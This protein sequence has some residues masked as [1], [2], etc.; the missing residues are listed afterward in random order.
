MKGVWLLL[1]LLAS[2]PLVRAQDDALSADELM[3]SAEQWAKENLDDDAL[4][5][6]QNVDRGKVKKFLTDIQKEFHG[7][8]VVDLAALRGTA[9]WV[10]PLLE[11]YE[12][13]YPYALWLKRRL[14]YLD[15]A[16]ELPLRID[17]KSV[18]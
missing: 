3:R 11:Q 17:R 12:E 2:A 13:T 15:T 4:R 9:H 5:A 7:D 14:D 1:I 18:V 10:E 16:D 6:L 8:Y